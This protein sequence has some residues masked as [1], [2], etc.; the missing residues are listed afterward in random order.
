MYGPEGMRT[1][2]ACDEFLQLKNHSLQ[3]RLGGCVVVLDAVQEAG[4][5]PIYV[6]LDIVQRGL[7]DSGQVG[8][9]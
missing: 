5:A 3:A 4:E 8:R 7:G 2:Q 1:I 9:L 6:R